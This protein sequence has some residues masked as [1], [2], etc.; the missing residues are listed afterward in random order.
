MSRKVVFPLETC[1][2]PF[3]RNLSSLSPFVNPS[4]T[5]ECLECLQL[6]VRARVRLRVF[7]FHEKIHFRICSSYW[8]LENHICTNATRMSWILAALL[9]EEKTQSLQSSSHLCGLAASLCLPC[10]RRGHSNEGHRNECLCLKC[11]I[12]TVLRPYH[13]Q[14]G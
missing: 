13:K 7:I 12:C 3:Y 2:S 9:S 4:C 6:R 8:I 1:L 14:L 11:M 10:E 5:A